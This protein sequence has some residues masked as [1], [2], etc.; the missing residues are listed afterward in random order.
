MKHIGRIR[1]SQLKCNFPVN[2]KDEKV[3]SLLY[4]D[5]QFPGQKLDNIIRSGKELKCNIWVINCQYIDMLYIIKDI[6]K[7]YE[8]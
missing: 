1:E 6:K 8:I 4:D 5:N 7:I 3:I 2:Y